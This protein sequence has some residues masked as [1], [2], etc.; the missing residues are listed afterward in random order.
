MVKKS[1]W[2]CV[3]HL[4]LELFGPSYGYNMTVQFYAVGSILEIAFVVSLYCI[5]RILFIS[6]TQFL[7]VLGRTTL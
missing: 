4:D 1:P 7:T 3:G 2:A 5:K 6:Y